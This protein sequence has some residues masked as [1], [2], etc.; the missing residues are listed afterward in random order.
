MNIQIA[1]P[2]DTTAIADMAVAFRNHLQRSTPTQAQFEDSISRL[3]AAPDAQFYIATNDGAP[4][5]YVLQR[6]RYSMWACGTEASI[7]DLFVDPS[8]RK[9]GVGKALIEFALRAASTHGC[10]SVCL[11]TN[12]NNAGSTAIYTQLG[13]SAMSA[14]WNGRQ[15]FFRK[16]LLQ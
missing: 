5:G 14:R 16:S 10:S 12:E 11:D 2:A 3:L 9:M 8:A 7:E 15:I 6:F 13:F 4:I 1:S